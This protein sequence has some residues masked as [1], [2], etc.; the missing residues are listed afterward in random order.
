MATKLISRIRSA[1]GVELAIRTLFEAPTVA[2]LWE[3]LSVGGQSDSFDILIPIRPT[4]N[5]APLF[6]MHPGGGLSWG[7]ASLIKHLQRERPV[8]GLQAR[9]FSD[10]NRMPGSIEEMAFDYLEQI[11]KVQSTG[12]YNLLGWSFGGYVAYEISRI[13][14]EDGETDITLTLLDTYPPHIKVP[15]EYLSGANQAVAPAQI[16]RKRK[17]E[18]PEI[19]HLQQNSILASLNK[20]E[21]E[22]MQRVTRHNVSLLKDYTPKGYNGNLTLFVATHSRALPSADVWLPFIAGKVNIHE[23][24]CRHGE[25]TDPTPMAQI[26]KILDAGLGTR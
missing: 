6:C 8:Y 17:S 19:Y 13:L 18:Q 11:R 12:P 14:F 26:G 20:E 7:Y 21:A 16:E 9:G 5:L 1:L 25:M 23:I 3:R 22:K 24:A 15:K 2:Q 4:G 10:L